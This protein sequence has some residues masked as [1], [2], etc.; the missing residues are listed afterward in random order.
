MGRESHDSTSVQSSIALLQERFRQL[1]RVKE[2]REERELLKM[3]TEPKQFSSNMRSTYESISSLSKPELII[4]SRSPP[5]H[6]SLSLWPTTSQEDHHKS[7]VQNT[8]V[9]QVSMNLFPTDYTHKQFMQ[10]SWKKNA[11][12]WDC[13]SDH[14]DVDTSLHL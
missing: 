6:V 5:P 3:Y 14:S 12:D 4:P 7:T 9:S 10:G 1:E 13:G 8:Q 11:Y 2:M